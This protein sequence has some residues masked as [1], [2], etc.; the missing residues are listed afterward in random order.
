MTK[1]DAEGG[2]VWLDQFLGNLSEDQRGRI[3]YLAQHDYSGNPSGI[4]AKAQAAHKKYGRKIWLTEFAVGNGADRESNDKFLAK[5]LPLLEAC[6]SVARYAWFSTRN[7]PKAWVA[8][9]SLLP[10]EEKQQEQISM[11]PTS[12]GKIY[13]GL[14]SR[15]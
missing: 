8:E 5:A 13:A 6:D 2:S 7:E 15:N 10:P 3:R 1:W 12:T 9:S 11:V 14:N 4:V